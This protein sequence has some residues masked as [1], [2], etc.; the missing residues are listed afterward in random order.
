[1]GPAPAEAE[2]DESERRPGRRTPRSGL[3]LGRIAGIAIR[4]D[5]SLLIIFVL[6]SVTLGSGLLP[7]WHPAWPAAKSWTV[8]IAAALLFLGSVLAHE[9]S[10]ALVARSYGTEVR[11]ITLFVFGGVAELEREP[12][13]WISELAMAIVGPVTSLVIGIACLAAA[14]SLMGHIV[15]DPAHPARALAHL[16]AAPTLLLWLGQ[17]NI[18][19]ALFNL[20]PG[21]PL[22][23]GRVLRAIVWGITGNLHAATRWASTVGQAFAWLLIAAGLAM[24]LGVNVPLFGSGFATGV[25]FAFIGWFLNSAAVASYRQLVVREALEHVPVARIMQSEFAVVPPELS[26][27]ELVD[28]FFLHS[29]QRAFPVVEGGRL[30]GLVSLGD[31]HRADRTRWDATAVRAVMTPAG[32]LATIGVRDDALE[33]L[34]I[35]GRRGVSQLP[36]VEEGRVV[37]LVRREDLLK[38]MALRGG[39]G[40]ARGA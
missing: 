3:H 40:R 21:F 5:W 12:Q 17:T 2:L 22:D 9:L 28:R 8:A 23:G 35:L 18:I 10:H 29:G 26:L 1:M 15:L 19:L 6:L 33:A 7:L 36:V 31:V 34:T 16:G 30:A 38:W 39:A 25:W 13:R 32:A 24:I 4:A 27:A 11:R 14:R 20:V 37:G